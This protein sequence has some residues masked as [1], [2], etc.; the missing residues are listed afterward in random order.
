MA[1]KKETKLRV[2]TTINAQANHKKKKEDKCL[3]CKAEMK[4]TWGVERS[5]SNWPADFHNTA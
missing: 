4:A 1:E 3:V 5:S 2:A